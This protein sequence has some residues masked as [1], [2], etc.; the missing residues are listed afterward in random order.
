MKQLEA[1]NPMDSEVERIVDE[2]Y[3]DVSKLI[4]EWKIN[5]AVNRNGASLTD[6]RNHRLGTMKFSEELIDAITDELLSRIIDDGELNETAY[7][8]VRE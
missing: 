8:E 6:Y 1:R 4:L 2:I 7:L 3:E 5:H